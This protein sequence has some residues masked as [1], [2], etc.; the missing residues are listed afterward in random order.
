MDRLI[1]AL[2]QIQEFKF[3]ND[4]DFVDRLNRQYTP[5]VFILFT[6]LVSIRHYVGDPISCWCP[7]QFT[8]AHIVSII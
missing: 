4:D 3:R 7:A 1:K 8:R 6:I 5:T 2:F